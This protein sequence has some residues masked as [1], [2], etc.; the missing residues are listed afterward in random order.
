[1]RIK[2]EAFGPIV[3]ADITFG[4]LTVLVGP[5][6][7][8]KSILLQLLKLLLDRRSIHAEMQRFGLEWG[9]ASEFSQLYFG[10]GSALL[11]SESSLLRRDGKKVE[12]TSLTG[13][14]RS[15]HEASESLFYI[16]AQRVMGVRDGLTRPFSDYRAGDPFV[17][18]AFSEKLHE[19]VQTDFSTP[20]GLFPRRN[21]LK[22][23]LRA[24]LADRIF[25]GFELRTEVSQMQRR[26]VLQNEE[27]TVLP[28]LVWSAGQREFM[29]LLLGFYHLLPPAKIARRDQL[30]WVV[31]EELEMGLHPHAITAVL[32]VVIELLW[33]GY[34]VCL[35]THS[36]HVLDLIW[37][38]RFLQD[39]DG[40]VPDVLRLLGLERRN[41]TAALAETALHGDFR[42]YY[43]SRGADVHDISRLDPGADDDAER[44]WGGLTEFSGTAAEV[45]AEV[46]N[47]RG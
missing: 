2:V 45:V 22:Q 16:P 32:A 26:I 44:G 15:R 29:P 17:L 18:R 46:A 37:A 10:E 36:P 34:R 40:G 13:S 12:L 20:A 39:N 14:R 8:G 24:P 30:E 19:L 25:A 23:A 3:D 7:T 42:V 11:A 33:R 21:R 28:F 1:M 27:G 5:Q 4:D 9:D 47:R 6:A 38:L 41:P 35:S 43:F 31:I